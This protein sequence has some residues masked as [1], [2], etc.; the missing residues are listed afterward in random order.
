MLDMLLSSCLLRVE[1]VNFRFVASETVGTMYVGPRSMRTSMRDSTQHPR[2]TNDRH[3]HD[4]RH[5]NAINRHSIFGARVGVGVGRESKMEQT[6]GHVTTSSDSTSSRPSYAQVFDVRRSTI[7]TWQSWK[8]SKQTANIQYPHQKLTVIGI[9][10]FE[11]THPT[12]TSSAHKSIRWATT[13]CPHREHL[14][15]IPTR[16]RPTTHSGIS[17]RHKTSSRLHISRLPAHHQHG[18][19]R[20]H[21]NTKKSISHHRALLQDHRQTSNLLPAPLQAMAQAS[22]HHLHTI[23]GWPSRTA[24]SSHHLPLSNKTPHPQPTQTGM[25]QPAATPGSTQ[26]PSGSR[27]N[28]TNKL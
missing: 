19:T 3:G 9:K 16:V 22:Q 23:P 2:H 5:E 13:I 28:T 24:V 11:L 6:K 26:T 20:S 1:P 25:T 17:N 12:H 4:Y 27:V 18:P 10:R 8:Q 7:K 14:Q 21:S 15:A